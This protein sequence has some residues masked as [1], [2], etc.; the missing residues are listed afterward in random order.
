MLVLKD[1]AEVFA[2]LGDPVR[3]KLV[4]KLIDHKLHSISSL[5]TG[6]KISR[7]AVTRH[8][9][10]L[11][12]VGLVT[13]TQEGQNTLYVLEVGPIKTLQQHLELISS[14]WDQSMRGLKKFVEEC[15]D[16]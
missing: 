9:T 15:E 13:N 1:Q 8:L 12:N 4:D 7:Q 10:V 16:L 3:L 5:T 6:T 14:R 11:E 2:A